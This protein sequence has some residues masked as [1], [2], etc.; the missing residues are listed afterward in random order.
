MKITSYIPPGV[1]HQAIVGEPPADLSAEVAHL[2]SSVAALKHALAMQ[3]QTIAEKDGELA[4][5]LDKLAELTTPPP[6]FVGPALRLQ[7]VDGQTAVAD[8]AP[9]FTGEGLAFADLDADDTFIVAGD[10]RLGIT[11]DVGAH[12]VLAR[13]LDRWG[14]S[15]EAVVAHIVG[16]AAPI[17]TP[18]PPAPPPVLMPV[19]EQWRF[20]T[21]DAMEGPSPSKWCSSLNIAW[22]NPMGDFLDG[23]RVPQG[24]TPFSTQVVDSMDPIVVRVAD[25]QAFKKGFLFTIA[26]KSSP[27]AY[28]AGRLS[29]KAP[30][31]R[32]TMRDGSTRDAELWCVAGWSS[33]STKALDT[34]QMAKLGP[35]D[36]VLVQFVIPEEAVSGVLTMQM[37]SRN[38]YPGTLSLFAADVPGIRLPWLEQPVYGLAKA[39][40][41]EAGLKGHPSI[42]VAGDFSAASM[43]AM[44]DQLSI[45]D[46][47][48]P[49]YIVEANGRT[50]FRGQFRS[51]YEIAAETGNTLAWVDQNSR[52]SF[53]GLVQI[54]G[55]DLT[56]PKRPP[57]SGPVEMYSRMCIKLH[58]NWRARN[59]G[60]KMAIGWDGRLGVW[61]DGGGKLQGYWQQTTGNGGAR[62]TGLMV[63][64]PPGRVTAQK[65]P[66]W[67]VQ[68]HSIR[69]E[70]GTQPMQPDDPYERFR[71][72]NS[73]TY[74]LD[75]FDF[76]GTI[77]R[78][79]NSVI[80]R[81]RKHSIEQM[82]RLNT[83]RGLTR[84]E[85]MLEWRGEMYDLRLAGEQAR[86]YHQYMAEL[87]PKTGVLYTPTEAHAKAQVDAPKTLTAALALWTFDELKAEGVRLQAQRPNHPLLTFDANGYDPFGNGWANA[88]GA[89][90]TWIDGVLVMMREGLRF[91][92]NP[93]MV[94][95]GPWLNWFFGGKQAS[96][97]TMTYEMSDLA[98]GYEYIGPPVD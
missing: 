78:F 97:C 94:I 4:R 13:A 71:G 56:D 61:V 41:G 83:V 18:P 20:R 52:G 3:E 8:I 49:E 57:L 47:C 32:L 6:V 80:E 95:E 16:E 45:S 75:Q 62:G 23:N 25:A 11:F 10:G 38:A 69:M 51:R 54:V 85:M 98:V 64:A 65:E 2:L 55:A 24:S 33:S 92:R 66:R 82:L 22:K 5:L 48:K 31:L 50:T 91:R 7:G 21:T 34:R 30:T 90:G 87:N 46:N 40:G 93:A 44:F 17:P 29:G 15:V 19:G 96:E 36:R 37:I 28:I 73:Y 27:T 9:L 86:L 12:D 1:E 79:G 88:D 14:R 76:N 63:L 70:S 43:K 53:G 39:V 68:G 81:G 58:D 89:L 60:N 77:E 42:I 59:D 67:E 74:H 26:G 35:T 84:D 72:P